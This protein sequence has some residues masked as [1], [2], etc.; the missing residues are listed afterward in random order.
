M[1]GGET[2]AVEGFTTTND[3]LCMRMIDTINGLYDSFPEKRDGNLTHGRAAISSEVLGTYMDLMPNEDLDTKNGC[4]LRDFAC[5]LLISKAGVTDADIG[6]LTNREILEFARLLCKTGDGPGVKNAVEFNRT[7]KDTSALLNGKS[8]DEIVGDD[9]SEGREA[10][11]DNLAV[12]SAKIRQAVQA[13]EDGDNTATVEHG[14]LKNDAKLNL[15]VLILLATKSVSAGSATD[16]SGQAKVKSVLEPDFVAKLAKGFLDAFSDGADLTALTNGQVDAIKRALDSQETKPAVTALAEKADHALLIGTLR[17][18]HFVNVAPAQIA[19][20]DVELTAKKTTDESNALT[21][22]NY[23]KGD[24]S[25]AEFSSPQAL[26]NVVLQFAQI[27]TN[28]DM[29]KA[30]TTKALLTAD[31][32]RCSS[33]KPSISRSRHSS[34]WPRPGAGSSPTSGPS[35]R[36]RRSVPMKHRILVPPVS[37]RCNLRRLACGQGVG[38]ATAS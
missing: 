33:Q 34:T 25:Y 35:R 15:D 19:A 28:P 30:T 37:C 11:V 36:R 1:I 16:P 5:G 32:N 2:R 18:G 10:R 17:K 12:M 13:M 9:H 22:V 4:L 24:A 21:A 27:A 14:A 7:F 20:D 38:P 6:T 8:I 26:K 23:L 3:E 31:N 29:H